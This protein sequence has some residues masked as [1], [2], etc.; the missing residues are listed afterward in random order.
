MTEK[1][2]S[3]E[4]ALAVLQKHWKKLFFVAATIVILIFMVAIVGESLLSQG[5]RRVV[6]SAQFAQMP[7]SI[8][9][10]VTFVRDEILL[11]QA[12]D[13]MLVMLVEP[14]DRVALE[15][16]VAVLS[17][18][19]QQAEAL[20]QH[21]ALTQRLR[22]L[23]EASEA[24]HHHALNVEQLG[25]QVDDT[26]VQLLREFERGM[27]GQA[28]QQ[29]EVF[30]QRATSLEAALGANIDFSGEIAAVQ[31]QLAALAPELGHAGYVTAPAS[32]QFHAATDGLEHLLTPASLRN[33]TPELFASLRENEPEQTPS[34][35][36]LVTNFRWY[37]VAELELGLAQQLRVGTTYTVRFPL[38]SA[39]E[40]M[41]QVE[42]IERGQGRY[43]VVVLSS[44]EQDETVANLR[45]AQAEIVVDT[46]EG[47]A[48]PAAA[49]RFVPKGEGERERTV[50]AVYITHG[51]QLRLREVDVLHQDAHVAIIAWGNL[52]EAQRVEGDRL[53]IEGQIQSATQPQ[54]GRLLL[55]GQGMRM[56]LQRDNTEQVIPGGPDLITLRQIRLF[57]ETIITG[58]NMQIERLN[59]DTLV[60]TGSDFIYREQRGTSLKIHD[61]VLVEGRIG[62]N[63]PR[64]ISEDS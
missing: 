4:E 26:F 24:T 21:Q 37:A 53:V 64:T 5:G 49:I 57:N 30:L 25:R 39:R 51:G 34:M 60:I 27:G 2:T 31:A 12:E 20:A 48:I 56:T 16:N 50:T 28:L 19:P 44:L 29:H 62:D 8:T 45:Y 42:R 17:R 35:G 38:E 3:S 6:A 9:A 46:V 63:D 36:R 58:Q 59:D 32:G 1:K 10:Q 23:T 33:I 22:W 15:Q 52:R 7:V 41:M 11:P 14:G 47:L 18:S 55:L 43:A 13:G 40:F 54:D 61:N